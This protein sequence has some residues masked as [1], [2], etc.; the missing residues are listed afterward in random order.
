MLE[1]LFVRT[2]HCMT[3]CAK[4]I[5]DG[6]LVHAQPF[7]QLVRADNPRVVGET[8]QFTAH[9]PRH[10]QSHRTRQNAARNLG[11]MF[12][13]RFETGMFD[14][15][16]RGRFAQCDRAII[17]DRGDGKARVATNIYRN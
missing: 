15:F 4:V 1:M 2:R 10:R 11:E 6:D 8:D 16:Q 14:G 13:C 12:P 7:G 9:R 5:D 3:H 17:A